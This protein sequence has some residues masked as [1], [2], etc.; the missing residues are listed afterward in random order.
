MAKFI[1][2][3]NKQ[4]IAQLSDAEPLHTAYREALLQYLIGNDESLQEEV[5]IAQL[6]LKGLLLRAGINVLDHFIEKVLI[7]VIRFITP[8]EELMYLFNNKIL[9]LLYTMSPYAKTAGCRATN[10]LRVWYY[11]PLSSVV[12]AIH[13]RRYEWI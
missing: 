7:Q 13:P 1:E 2:V 12:S 4:T 11:G 9:A 5:I 3:S 10:V 8:T 6:A